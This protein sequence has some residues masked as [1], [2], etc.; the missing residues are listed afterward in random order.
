M[1]NFKAQDLILTLKVKLA[2]L[3]LT[4]RTAIT[5]ASFF[6][7]FCFIKT[8][9]K[10]QNSFVSCGFV[11]GLLASLC[12]QVIIVIIVMHIL[13]IFMKFAQYK[14][15]YYFSYYVAPICLFIQM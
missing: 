11:L 4:M 9:L 10:A 2:S 13:N 6:F 15:H 3:D 7:F 8:K 12:H 5:D 1:K 14:I